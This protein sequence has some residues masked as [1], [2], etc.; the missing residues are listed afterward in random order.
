MLRAP[1][2]SYGADLG[3]GVAWG[4]GWGLDDEWF[5]R[6]S[7]PITNAE[8]RAVDSKSWC[9]RRSACSGTSAPAETRS[10]LAFA[11]L[12]LRVIVVERRADDCERMRPKAGVRV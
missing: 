12:G 6:R 5:A 8:V 7:G 9:S 10:P 2:P 11:R 3:M 1:D 4:L